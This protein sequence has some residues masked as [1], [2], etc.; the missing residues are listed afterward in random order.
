MMTGSRKKRPVILVNVY[1]FFLLDRM[2]LSVDIT[3]A[4]ASAGKTTEGSAECLAE[5]TFGRSLLERILVRFFHCHLGKKGVL[6]AYF[7]F[8]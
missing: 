5:G 7:A 2:S 8:I 1:E 6:R 4:S 3:E